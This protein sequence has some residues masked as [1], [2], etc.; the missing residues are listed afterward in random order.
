MASGCAPPANGC[1]APSANSSGWIARSTDRKEPSS[2]SSCRCVSRPPPS[3]SR[4]C[5]P[6]D[7]IR[8]LIVDDERPA[9]RALR[10][11]LDKQP[12]ID[13]VGEATDGER[14]LEFIKEHRPQLM[15]LDVQMP[16]M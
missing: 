7:K 14:A 12:D 13:L 11:L 1:S 16:I 10:G 3:R 2:P 8:T 9:L 6:M 15:F 4:R 5:N